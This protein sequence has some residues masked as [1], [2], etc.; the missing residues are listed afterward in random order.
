MP[1]SAALAGRAQRHGDDSI[2]DRVPAMLR[3]PDMGVR[4]EALLYL[5][6]EAGVDPLRQIEELGDFQDF[7]IRAGAAAFL[8]APGPRESRGGAADDRG[9]GAQCRAGGERDRTDR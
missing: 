5:S 9:H 3:D 7:S 8:S 4:T 2:A 1:T 6:R